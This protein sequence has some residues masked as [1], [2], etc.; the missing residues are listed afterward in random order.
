MEEKIAKIC[1]NGHKYYHTSDCPACPTCWKEYKANHTS[2]FDGMSAP[3][4]RALETAGIKTLVDLAKWTQKDILK[5]HGMGSASI[6][7]MK[8]KLKEINADFASNK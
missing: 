2:E 1:L 8:A 7:M 6:P 5:L 4:Q 3:A